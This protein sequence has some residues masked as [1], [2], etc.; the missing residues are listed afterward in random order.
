[1]H[2]TLLESERSFSRTPE[3]AFAS[4]LSHAAIVVLALGLA[5]GGRLLSTPESQAKPLFL[6]PPDRMDVES[7]Q[8]EI[9]Q[10]GRPGGLLDGG[11]ELT[12]PGDGGRVG[13][14]SYGPHRHGE[15]SATQGEV[16][17]GPPALL[18]DS[19]FSLVEVDEVVERFEDSAAPVYPEELAA[20]G[21]E[22]QVRATYVV[23]ADGRVDMT[24]I[25]VLNSD[26]PR[27]TESVRV[28][29]GEMRFRPA[30]KAG[31]TVRQL[32]EQRFNFRLSASLQLP[33]LQLPK[34]IS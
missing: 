31:K 27:F 4:M 12:G 11:V 33:K 23:D 7:R 5:D 6:P 29:L 32:V 30:K 19:V 17:F 15:R 1:M 24:T 25:R 3:W 14:H 9:F 18:S 26:H 21:T 20:L 22:G 10:W 16:P 8:T 13:G 28:A 2:L 34:Q